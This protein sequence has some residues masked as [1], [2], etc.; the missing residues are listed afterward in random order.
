MRRFMEPHDGQDRRT[1]ID[2]SGTSSRMA[3]QSPQ[4]TVGLSSVLTAPVLAKGRGKDLS[5]TNGLDQMERDKI[6][7][8]VCISSSNCWDDS[9]RSHLL[10]K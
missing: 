7:S 4:V 8:T 3:R 1:S 5:L 9:A 2:V 6:Q 10:Q